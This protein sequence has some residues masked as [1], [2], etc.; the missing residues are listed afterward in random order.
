VKYVRNNGLKGHAFKSLGAENAHLT[1]WETHIADK[2]IHGTTCKQVGALFEEERA[3]LQPLPISL[4]PIK[5]WG[6]TGGL[7]HAVGSKMLR[8]F[9]GVPAGFFYSSPVPPLPSFV[10]TLAKRHDRKKMLKREI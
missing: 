3:H 6:R 4:F 8:R 1:Q 9:L 5:L 10:F 7:F 2:R